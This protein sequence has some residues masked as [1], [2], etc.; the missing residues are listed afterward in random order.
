MAYPG[1]TFRAIGPQDMEFLFQVYASTRM[2][3]LAAVDWDDAQK[4][5]FL[6]MQF[7][8]QHTYY[9]EHYRDSEFD[10]ILLHGEPVGRLYLARWEDYNVPRNLD[11]ELG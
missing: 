9:Q 8:A 4:T 11:S 2:D 10:I 7:H 1:M 5:A 6:N 3:E